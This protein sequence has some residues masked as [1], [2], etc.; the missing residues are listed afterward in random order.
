MQ[1]AERQGDSGLG[2][3][4]R[5]LAPSVVIIGFAHFVNRASKWPDPVRK[6]RRAEVQ[7]RS[8]ASTVPWR[9]CQSKSEQAFSECG[10]AWL[11]K[12]VHAWNTN[13]AVDITGPSH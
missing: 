12:A 11:E 2:R 8:K 3:E 5:V 10:A 4:S 7:E 1:K 9:C 13:D 6:E